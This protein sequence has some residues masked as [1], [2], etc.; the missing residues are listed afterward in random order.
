[1]LLYPGIAPNARDGNQAPLGS[2]LGAEPRSHKL[3]VSGQIYAQG[4]PV[5]NPVEEPFEQGFPSNEGTITFSVSQSPGQGDADALMSDA[6][7]QKLNPL[8][9]LLILGAIAR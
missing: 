7:H 8:T 1:M 9:T 4:R 6:Q 2:G 3:P 5:L